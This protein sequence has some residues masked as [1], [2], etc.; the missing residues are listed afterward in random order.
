MSPIAARSD[1]M[2]A[3]MKA[4]ALQEDSASRREPPLLP[5]ELVE[6]I[7]AQ[8]PYRTAILKKC[9]LVARSWVTPCRARLFAHL[10]LYPRAYPSGLLDLSESDLAL[11][12]PP[13]I[14]HQLIA[15]LAMPAAFATAPDIPQYVRGL[16][17]Q[18]MR[19]ATPSDR[20]A[21]AEAAVQVLQ[22]FPRLHTLTLD[23]RA[24]D[25]PDFSPALQAALCGILAQ[26]SLTSLHLREQDVT[27]AGVH[28]LLRS[29][30]R[31]S[32]QCGADAQASA[33]SKGPTR[34]RVCSC[35]RGAPAGSAGTSSP[36]RRT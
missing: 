1:E 7:V 18:M 27:D 20:A 21:A 19:L 4:L 2:H 35:G 17:V 36:S 12:A 14:R 15:L 8:L 9:C 5:V 28:A 30:R 31:S 26:P 22:L 34:W 3:K 23:T 10:S 16:S 29:A 32:G 24:L 11:T 6:E 13:T 25:Y 33:A